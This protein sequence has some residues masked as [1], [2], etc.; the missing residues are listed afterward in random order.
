[1]IAAS[2]VCRRSFEIYQVNLASTGLQRPIETASSSVLSRLAALVPP[3]PTKP[4]SSSRARA[5]I[6]AVQ[7]AFEFLDP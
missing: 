4:V 5:R 3:R 2:K 6:A 1:M 7:F